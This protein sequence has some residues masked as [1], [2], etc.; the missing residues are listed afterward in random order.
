MRCCCSL[1]VLQK[2]FKG[3]CKE[4]PLTG[5]YAGL[6][7]T[8]GPYLN[9]MGVSESQLAGSSSLPFASL[10]TTC[11]SLVSRTHM[12]VVCRPVDHQ[13]TQLEPRR[14]SGGG[15]SHPTLL[16]ALG[17]TLLLLA[18][19]TRGLAQLSQS[20]RNRIHSHHSVPCQESHHSVRMQGLTH[21]HT[22]NDA[23]ANW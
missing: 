16:A 5:M 8:P 11:P 2:A 3:V 4:R 10:H 17:P 12:I 13:K 9:R 7:C 20:C 6:C 18:L 14:F 22:P 19:P 23:G 21:A 15:P 1:A